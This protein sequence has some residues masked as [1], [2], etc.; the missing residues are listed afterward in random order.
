MTIEE[1]IFY[2]AFL[3]VTAQTD[4]HHEA[5][6]EHAS[7]KDLIAKIEASGPEDDYFDSRVKVLSEMIKHHVKEE[8]QQDGMFAKAIKSRMNMVELGQQMQARKEG[9]MGEATP[10]RSRTTQPQVAP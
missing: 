9:L 7:A 10:R 3:K 4:I 1:E 8:E 6:I 5:E 2:P